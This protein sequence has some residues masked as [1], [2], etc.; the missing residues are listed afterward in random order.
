MTAPPTTMYAAVNV[1]L[2]SAITLF[3]LSLGQCATNERQAQQ[4]AALQGRVSAMAISDTLG[5]GTVIMWQV[6]VE[7]LHER[8]EHESRRIDTLR[9]IGS[10]RDGRSR[11]AP[12]P[13]RG[14]WGDGYGVRAATG[15]R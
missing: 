13:K 12:M 1:L 5:A 8:I 11:P 14:L 15:R 4:I 7:A 6:T 9:D 2:F 10:L 3:I